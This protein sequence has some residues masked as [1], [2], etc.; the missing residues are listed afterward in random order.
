ML[1]E[2]KKITLLLGIYPEVVLLDHRVCICLPLFG[3][4]K[5]FFRMVVSLY[6]LTSDL[7]EFRVLHHLH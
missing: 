3:T 4:A 5:H 7:V 1:L 6:I 2:K